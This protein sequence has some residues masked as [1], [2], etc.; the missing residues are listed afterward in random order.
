MPAMVSVI[1]ERENRRRGLWAWVA[2]AALVV[3]TMAGMVSYGTVFRNPLLRPGQ[4]LPAVPVLDLTEA[5][6]VE[7][8]LDTRV[9]GVV[10]VL[11]MT[12]TC[13][14]CTADLLE[15][16]QQAEADPDRSAETSLSGLML[17]VIRSD[18]IPRAVFMDA[19]RRGLD[20]GMRTLTILPEQARAMGIARVPAEIRLG[21]DGRVESI[22]YRQGEDVSR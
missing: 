22:A 6:P 17:L 8:L 16:I 18:G 3:A 21:P 10:E 9:E 14:V 20:L 15:R 12:P 1:E 19:Y 13:D 11:V 2:V 7:H 4:P 5:G